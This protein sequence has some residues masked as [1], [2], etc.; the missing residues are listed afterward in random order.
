MGIIGKEQGGGWRIENH[1]EETSGSGRFWLR[2]RQT[3][4]IRHHLGHGDGEEFGQ[5]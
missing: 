4:V 5:M 2:P 1:K 3:K